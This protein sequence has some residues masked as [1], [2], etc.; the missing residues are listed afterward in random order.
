MIIGLWWVS[1]GN[2]E[3][4]H[5]G[6]LRLGTTKQVFRFTDLWKAMITNPVCCMKPG[7]LRRTRIE[8][9]SVPNQYFVRCAVAIGI[10]LTDGVQPFLEKQAIYGRSLRDGQNRSYF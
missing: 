1:P 4:F 6:S 7:M 5:C 8:N 3:R 2:G 9:S 10:I